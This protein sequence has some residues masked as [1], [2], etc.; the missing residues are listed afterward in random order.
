M[1]VLNRVELRC[2]PLKVSY[3]SLMYM[4]LGERRRRRGGKTLSGGWLSYSFHSLRR[5]DVAVDAAIVGVVPRGCWY[6]VV[7]GR[8]RWN[9]EHKTL[10]TQPGTAW[11]VTPSHSF[12]HPSTRPPFLTYFPIT[13]MKYSTT[14]L[15]TPRAIRLDVIDSPLLFSRATTSST[16]QIYYS[17]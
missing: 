2:T 15:I 8:G 9:M 12:F 3:P 11:H 5:I 16:T 14:L 10:Q 4:N 17:F 13:Y 1:S 7:G 6:G